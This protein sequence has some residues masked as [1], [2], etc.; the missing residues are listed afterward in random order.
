[1]YHSTQCVKG[2]VASRKTLLKRAKI[3][4][5]YTQVI[6]NY[7]A[8]YRLKSPPGVDDFLDSL[9]FLAA[10]FFPYFKGCLWGA[11]FLDETLLMSLA[12]IGVLFVWGVAQRAQ[13]AYVARRHWG[14]AGEE[15]AKKQWKQW[16]FAFCTI[17]FVAYTSVS[18][19]LFKFFDCEAFE[20]GSH[21]M[22]ADARVSCDGDAYKAMAPFFEK[23]DQRIQKLRAKWEANGMVLWPQILSKVLRWCLSIPHFYM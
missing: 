2:M 9:R 8:A 1:M 3:L 19:Q 12:P 17:S 18:V 14:I 5:S 16:L 15:I 6:T 7:A 23:A 10:D 4:V 13:N 11:D 22:M 20:D 21:V